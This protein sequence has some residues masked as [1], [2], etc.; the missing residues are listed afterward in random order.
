MKSLIWFIMFLLLV[1]LIIA[2]D[3]KG[4]V[5]V[6]YCPEDPAPSGEV[7]LFDSTYTLIDSTC[8]GEIVEY[9]YKFTG[10]P[11]GKYFVKVKVVSNEYCPYSITLR[12]YEQDDSTE[13]IIANSNGYANLYADVRTSVL[14]SCE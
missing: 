5:G 14:T 1:S 10:L 9:E 7:Y 6:P 8:I 3:I 11:N 12:P 4:I 13:V 2:Y